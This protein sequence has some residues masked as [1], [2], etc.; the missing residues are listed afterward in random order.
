[1]RLAL[2][3]KGQPYELVEV[4]AMQGEHKQPAHLARHPF[5]KVPAFE[6]DGFMLYETQ[7]I[8][9]Y[10]DQAF[11]GP[12]LTPA[13]IRKTARMNQIIGVIDSYAND[14]LI[15]KLVVQRLVVP[16]AGG[17]S[18]EA[19]IAGCLHNA[20]LSLAQIEAL[21]EGGTWLAGEALSLADIHLAPILTYVRMTPE[22]PDLL[23]PHPWLRGWW[24]RI[25]KRPSM[26]AT[27]PKFG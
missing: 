14:A 22:G 4:K 27:A 12:S 17:K 16:M 1:V 15:A 7:A 9:R 11:K 23:A 20:K 10:V 18:D 2:E 8:T 25:E 24:E 13:D 5:G 6:H 26:A 21:A 3:E 19:V